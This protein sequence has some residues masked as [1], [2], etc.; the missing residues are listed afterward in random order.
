MSKQHEQGRAIR[1][2]KTTTRVKTRITIMTLS[3]LG[4]VLELKQHS[5]YF[6]M[7]LKG[8][9]WVGLSFHQDKEQ[10]WLI[11]QHTL[12]WCHEGCSVVD[13]VLGEL[14]PRVAWVLIK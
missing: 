5:I 13:G 11:A 2:Y 10:R 9:L 6:A 3:R 14:S 4:K 8:P 1:N 12:E 7:W